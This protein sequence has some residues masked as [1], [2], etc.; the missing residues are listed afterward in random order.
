MC[1]TFN[2][3]NEDKVKTVESGGV[4]RGLSVLLDIQISDYTQG[5]FSE[6]VKVVIHGQGEFIDEWEGINIGPGQH[7]VISLAQRKV[8]INLHAVPSFLPSF[9]PV[10]S[11]SIPH[12]SNC[13]RYG[14]KSPVHITSVAI[15][16]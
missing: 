16:I 15:T 4:T 14:G 1:M 9:R 3:G 2:S 7:A 13:I 5:K 8:T 12:N 11:T 6:G 10:H